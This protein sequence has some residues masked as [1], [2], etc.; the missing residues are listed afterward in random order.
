MKI[1]VQFLRDTA[2]KLKQRRYHDNLPISEH[3]ETIFCQVEFLI[4]ADEIEGI[5][6]LKIPKARAPWRPPVVSAERGLQRCVE[7]I[8]ALPLAPRMIESR[9]VGRKNETLILKDL[10]RNNEAQD[11]PEKIS[12]P[13]YAPSEIPKPE[14]APRLEKRESPLNSPLNLARLVKSQHGCCAYC[15]RHFGGRVFSKRKIITLHATM[16]HF[17]PKS[18]GGEIFFA[19]CQMCNLLKSNYLFDDL[20]ACRKY[21]AEIWGRSGYRN[22][23][24]HFIANSRMFSTN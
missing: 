18:M 8:I 7:E 5:G 19:A 17:V 10:T 23:N 24:G 11:K 21:L 6:P 9:E 4:T 13:G 14:R 3:V 16:E 22:T 15:F 1:E 20:A 2:E 12:V